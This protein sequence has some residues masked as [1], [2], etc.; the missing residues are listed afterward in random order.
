MYK[1]TPRH[2]AP[3][4]RVMQITENA[5]MELDPESFVITSLIPLCEITHLI[6]CFNEAQMFMIE[7]VDRPTRR[8]SCSNRDALLGALLDICRMQGLT[9]AMLQVVETHPGIKIHTTEEE[10]AKNMELT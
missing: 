1:D 9:E 10:N 7:F 2:M 6:R 4:K 3:V 8:Y 5:L